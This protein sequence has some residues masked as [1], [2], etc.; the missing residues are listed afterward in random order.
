LPVFAAYV[1]IVGVTVAHHEPW[2]DEAQAW[3][4][5]RD[6]TW[7]D[8][9]C[10]LPRYEGSPMLW[11]L[12][13]A[14]PARCG[15]PF[16]SLNVIAAAIACGGVLMFLARSP[17]PKFLAATA[18]FTFFLVYQHAAVARSYV[19][20]PL[21]LFT[22]AD[23]YPSRFRRPLLF[24]APLG[25]LAHV[26]A[27][28][29]FIA[30]GLAGLLGF[31]ALRRWRRERDAAALQRAAL[32][33]GLFGLVAAA[34]A[35]QLRPPPDHYGG[36]GYQQPLWPTIQFALE[37]WSG[38]LADAY[39][40][41]LAVFAISVAWFWRT[42][43]LAIYALLTAAVLVLFVIANCW[44]HHEGILFFVWLFALWISF[45]EFRSPG[46]RETQRTARLRRGLSA[47]VA[48]VFALHV[49]WAFVS[50]REDFF[51]DYSGA[52][53]VAEYLKR[54]GLD[55]KRIAT[56]DIYALAGQ[57]YFDKNFRF[58]NFRNGR[59]SSF[60]VFANEYFHPSG[61]FRFPQPYQEPF[62]VL[63]LG[64]K[65]PP[66]CSLPWDDPAFE[67]PLSSDFRCV[68]YFPG[69]LWWKT[70]VYER[71]DYV[72]YVRKELQA[73]RHEPSAAAAAR[74]EVRVRNLERFGIEPEDEIGVPL[75]A[76]HAILGRMLEL[77]DRQAAIEHFRA[78]LQLWPG[79]ATHAALG[80]I[81]AKT[82]PGE[83]SQHLQTALS[84][85][86]NN[87]SAYAN[88]GYIHARAGRYDA[89]IVCYRNALALEPD[90]PA[91]RDGL[92][93]VLK[94]VRGDRQG[95]GAAETGNNPP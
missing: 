14:L 76:A 41:S 21:L 23:L 88:L 42:G 65:Q 35:W 3:L 25:L 5:A 12:L 17:L 43:A 51:F 77:L 60:V 10:T 16:A 37:R 75:A 90:L 30:A 54:E 62:D 93:A 81:L 11:H 61:L 66:F 39:V 18:P 47:A 48:V 38:A 94:I 82:N 27:H 91:V 95:A 20:M 92:A 83:A 84:L 57:P 55:S 86:P 50:I 40:P 6:A 1:V 26:S 85:N 64:V 71:D 53:A 87:A 70:D 56:S 67:L 46:F 78:A 58:A 79:S 63:I 72:C 22:C 34:A 74:R 9:L 32:A 13:L 28:G 7:S 2:F 33:L 36:L 68:G 44:F 52:K 19:L 24:V 4:I 73:S 59:G 29:L 8:L 89:A 69:N 15:L 49:Y 80:G 31:Q 45:Q